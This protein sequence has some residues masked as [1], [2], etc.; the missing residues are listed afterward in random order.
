MWPHKALGF[1]QPLTEMSAGNESSA[2]GAEAPLGS[3]TASAS[4]HAAARRL[5]SDASSVGSFTCPQALWKRIAVCTAALAPFK[6]WPS[7]GQ[8]LTYNMC[9]CKGEG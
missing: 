1:T 9:S 4:A 7:F 2:A 5:E 6:T 3:A 8:L